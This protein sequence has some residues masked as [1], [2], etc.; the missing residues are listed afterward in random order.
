MAHDQ[1]GFGRT[2]RPADGRYGRAAWTRHALALVDALGIERLHVV[3]NS[4]GGAIALSMAAERPELVE[5]LVLMG[6]TGVGFDLPPGSTRSGATSPG[7]SR[8]VGSWSSSPST[9]T[10]S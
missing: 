7:S 9:T 4:M 5:R 6:T 10:R 1:L 2:G 3:G 8:C